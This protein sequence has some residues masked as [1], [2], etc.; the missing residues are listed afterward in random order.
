MITAKCQQRVNQNQDSAGFLQDIYS[1][2]R[3]V[4]QETEQQTEHFTST[5]IEIYTKNHYG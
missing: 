1:Y 2:I 5:V 4:F 3:V